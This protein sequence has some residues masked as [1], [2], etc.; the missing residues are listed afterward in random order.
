MEAPCSV[1][2][3]VFYL[4]EDLID[5]KYLDYDLTSR[6]KIEWKCCKCFSIW[7]EA[8][9]SRKRYDECPSCQIRKPGK[10][11]EIKCFKSSHYNFPEF[12]WGSYCKNCCLPGMVHLSLNKCRDC[13]LYAYY[14]YPKEGKGIYCINHAKDKMINTNTRKCDECHKCAIYNY[15]S[16]KSPILCLDHKR[17]NMVNVTFNICEYCQKQASFNFPGISR[18]IYCKEHSKLHPGT[19]NVTKNLCRYSGCTITATYN[20]SGN[21]TGKFCNRHKLQNMID[22]RSPMCKICGKYASYNFYDVKTPEYCEIHSIEG[23]IDVKNITKI[24]KIEG[25]NNRG[26]YS[27]KN[28]K[29]LYCSRHKNYYMINTTRNKCTEGI[30]NTFA[31]Y[32]IPGQKPTHCSQH[33]KPGMIRHPTKRCEEC[34]ELAIYGYKKPSH[35]ESHKLDDHINLIE[36]KCKSCNLLNILLESDLCEYCDPINSKRYR[37]AKEMKVK[38]FFDTNDVHYDTQDRIVDRGECGMERP[39]FLFD[40]GTHF[41]IVEVDENQHNSRDSECEKKR[42]IN[43]SQ[44]LALPTWF[45]RYNPDK[46]KRKNSIKNVEGDNH[47][48]RMKKLL[49][50]LNHCKNNIPDTYLKAVYLYYNDWDGHGRMVNII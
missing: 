23:M 34:K 40:C 42:M 39:D 13:N 37:K 33:K 12:P 17:S 9:T 15:P 43:I 45:I 14:N 11:L 20:I 31:S 50:W 10:C 1:V 7:S 44:S 47:N 48:R 46:Y 6:S 25:C 41:V 18:G 30:C 49:L 4:V 36:H 8:I 24:C 3:D 27:V 21:K 2:K 35:C 16:Y 32:N 38:D 26:S 28:S 22:V 29:D 5:K 19:I